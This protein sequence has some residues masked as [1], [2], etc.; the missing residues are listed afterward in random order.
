MFKYERPS[1][2]E[3][4]I[5]DRSLVGSLTCEQTATLLERKLELQ[6]TLSEGASDDVL[7]EYNKLRELLLLSNMDLIDLC[8]KRY[9]Y[10][11]ELDQEDAMMTGIVGM[12]KGIDKFD[13]SKEFLKNNADVKTYFFRKYLFRTIINSIKNELSQLTSNNVPIEEVF[14]E[15]ELEDDCDIE[16]EII[17]TSLRDLISKYISLLNPRERQVIYLKY[18]KNLTIRKMVPIVGVSRSLVAKILKMAIIKL[19]G[20]TESN[21]L[22]EYCHEDGKTNSLIIIK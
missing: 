20:I 17:E 22:D 15:V 9:F 11:D 4:F 3:Q 7:D 12:I 5:L 19:K 13:S 14:S 8:F 2:S 6:S 10:Q 16:N 21:G 1:D 18:M